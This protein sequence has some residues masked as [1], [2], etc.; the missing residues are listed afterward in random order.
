MSRTKE[1]QIAITKFR[2]LIDEIPSFKHDFSEN[3]KGISWDGFINM[4]NGNIDKKSN[5]DYAIDVQIKGRTSSNKK[6]KPEV[7]NIFKEYP[8][9]IFM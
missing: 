4:F 9:A 1:E 7:L 6:L 3:D 2:A 5:F 8:I